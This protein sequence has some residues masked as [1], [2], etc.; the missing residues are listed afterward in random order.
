[1]EKAFSTSV[2]RFFCLPHL[3]GKYVAFGRVL[4]GWKNA[5]LLGSL[6]SESGLP[7]RDIKIARCY[8]LGAVAPK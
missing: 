5:V 4:D 6:G 1:M 3:N 8:K 2:T 7:K